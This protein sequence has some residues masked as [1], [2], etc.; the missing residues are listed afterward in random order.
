MVWKQDPT[1]FEEDNKACIDASVVQHMTKRMRHLALTENFL[2]EKF[3]DGT[4]VLKKVDQRTI[5][6]TSEPSDYSFLY[7]IICHS[8]SQTELSEKPRKTRSK[9]T[10]S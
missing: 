2:K 3:A 6:Q 4:C 9:D 7:L 10:L 5:T 1:L 8:P